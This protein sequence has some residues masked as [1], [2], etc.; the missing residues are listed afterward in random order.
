[1]TI[2]CNDDL[3]LGVVWIGAGIQQF[4]KDTSGAC[5]SRD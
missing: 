3:H 4:Y 2:Y 1:M 5:E